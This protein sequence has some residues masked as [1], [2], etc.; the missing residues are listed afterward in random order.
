MTKYQQLA[1]LG[2]T[3]GRYVP[4]QSIDDVTLLDCGT[5][6]RPSE[7]VRKFFQQN[8]EEMCKH[9]QDVLDSLNVVLSQPPKSNKRIV[10]LY[11]PFSAFV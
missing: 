10:L 11:D 4:L 1:Y 2:G 6:E 8:S 9:L 3:V 5:D 7:E